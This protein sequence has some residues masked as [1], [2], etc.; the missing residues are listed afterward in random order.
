MSS[1]IGLLGRFWS[2]AHKRALF[3]QKPI[4]LDLFEPS[5]PKSKSCTLS[6]KNA[7]P[8]TNFDPG[9]SQNSLR[10]QNLYQVLDPV[11]PNLIKIDRI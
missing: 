9:F 5:A 10:M 2:L 1:K 4:S 6:Q 3:G 11:R 8:T 7:D